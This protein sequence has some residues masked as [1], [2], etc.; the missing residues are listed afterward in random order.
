M[1][2]WSQLCSL[3]VGQIPFL[4]VRFQLM[5]ARAIVV[6]Q[7]EPRIALLI[8]NQGYSASVAPTCRAVVKNAL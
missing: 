4:Q 2:C 1:V 3:P 6:A 7:A 5:Q 8:G